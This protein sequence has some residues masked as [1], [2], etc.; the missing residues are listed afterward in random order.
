MVKLWKT[1]KITYGDLYQCSSYIF[2]L[3]AGLSTG[4]VEQLPRGPHILSIFIVWYSKVAPLLKA[5]MDTHMSKSGP[6]CANYIPKIQARLRPTDN[7]L[8]ADMFWI[9]KS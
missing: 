1:Q 3:R 2:L 7:Y 5:S 8:C 6:G 4:Q 9:N